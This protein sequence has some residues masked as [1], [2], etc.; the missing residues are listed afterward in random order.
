MQMEHKWNTE[1]VA[2]DK[3]KQEETRRNKK[4]QEETRRNKKK[5]SVSD[6]K[7]QKQKTSRKPARKPSPQQQE[8]TRMI[9]PP[10]PA[11]PTADNGVFHDVHPVHFHVTPVH[12]QRRT[13]KGRVGGHHGG[14][15]FRIT[16][17]NH[18]EATALVLRGVVVDFGPLPKRDVGAIP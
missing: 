16:V 9:D 15:Q 10:T 14:V 4:K 3:K 12:K 18:H 5:N 11:V 1:K 6:N 13:I 17:R 2:S 8:T 7:K